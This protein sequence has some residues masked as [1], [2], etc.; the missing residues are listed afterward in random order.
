MEVFFSH[1]I[2]LKYD[3]NKKGFLVY[4]SGDSRLLKLLQQEESKQTPR[5]TEKFHSPGQSADASILL[6][7]CVSG[8]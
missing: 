2:L 4:I 1:N 6:L 3:N 7:F 5:I 8:Q